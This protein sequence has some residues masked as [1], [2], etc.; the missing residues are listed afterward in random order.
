MLD[1]VDQILPDNDFWRA[2]VLGAF[3]LMSLPILAILATQAPSALLATV[4]LSFLA[5]ILDRTDVLDGETSSSGNESVDE[6]DA[7]ELLRRRYAT[8]E[9]SESEFE[10]RLNR[11][12]EAEPEAEPNRR[13]KQFEL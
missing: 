4:L 12:L 3:V 1:A 7:L 11:L 9:I 5:W 8:G 6:M 13:E 2:C 10:H